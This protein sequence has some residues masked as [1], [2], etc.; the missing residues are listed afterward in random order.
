MLGL[1][2]IILLDL[3]AAYVAYRKAGDRTLPWRF[4]VRRTIRWMLPVNQ[5]FVNRPVYSLC[6]IVF[7]IGLIVT[8]LF[9]FAHVELWRKAIG[10]GWPTLPKGLADWLTIITV[11][12]AVLLLVGRI[13]NRASRFI[14]RKQ[15]YL[16][17]AILV[18]PFV[19]G[20]VCANIG[21]TASVYQLVM[22]IH[23]LSAEVIFVLIP[24]TKIAHCVLMPLSQ[25]I[26]NLAWRFP[27]D[28][29]ADICATLN[30]KG[31]PV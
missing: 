16:W 25:F 29:D 26:S 9:L 18:T 27:A 8:P 14:S 2:R 21:T 28:T 31:A 1:A 10:F 22:L 7:H 15:D 20:Y 6:S 30:K 17:P 12:C 11:L 24:F 23:V 5:V 4:I 19:T 13:A 3:T